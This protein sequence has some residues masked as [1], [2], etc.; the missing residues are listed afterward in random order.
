[1][2]NVVRR[3]AGYMQATPSW[4]KFLRH[5]SV[6]NLHTNAISYVRSKTASYY[7]PKMSTKMQFGSRKYMF[8]LAR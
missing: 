3:H 1:M 4:S 8:I 6:N 2:D 7:M 5:F